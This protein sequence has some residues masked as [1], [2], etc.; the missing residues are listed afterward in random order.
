MG[1]RQRRWR[2][3]CS[4]QRALFRGRCQ[5]CLEKPA[6]SVR[7]LPTRLSSKGA[8]PGGP[9]FANVALVP[10]R[11]LRVRLSVE[12]HRMSRSACS[13]T[14]WCW[15]CVPSYRYPESEAIL[16]GGLASHAGT[17]AG[18][19]TL[20][21]SRR[22]PIIGRPVQSGGVRAALAPAGSAHETQ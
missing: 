12:S 6:G 8:F 17:P 14:V 5:W 18:I 19:R 3:V 20:P 15:Y 2:A 4:A 9:S 1:Q 11:V 22:T 21:G 16:N 13:S 7:S 10:F